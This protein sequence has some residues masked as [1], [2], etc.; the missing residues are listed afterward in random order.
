MANELAARTE[1][2]A[3]EAGALVLRDSEDLKRLAR[4]AV[5][6]KWT[7]MSASEAVCA[8]AQGL[9]I[10]MNPW[11]ALQS[12]AVINGRPCLWGD[13]MLGLIR[14]SGV[15]EDIQETLEGSGDAMVAVCRMKR[16]GQ[17]SWIERR[18]SVAEA[19]KAGLWGKSGTW[20][21]YP[22][23]MLPLRARSWACRDGFGDVLGGLYAAEEAQDIREGVEVRELE[24]PTEHGDAVREALDGQ[25]AAPSAPAPASFGTVDI[26]EEAPAV[27]SDPPLQPSDFPP[28]SVFNPEE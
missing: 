17:E 16:K 5:E 4:L 7:K 1:P 28:G 13:A 19:K 20:Q 15:L 2:I 25:H 6:A 27:T 10:G 14:K 8:I 3:L 22:T 12:I 26:D 21:S 11:Q 24:E 23:R 18:F 9:V